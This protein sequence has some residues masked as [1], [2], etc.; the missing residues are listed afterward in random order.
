MLALVGFETSGNIHAADL[1]ASGVPSARYEGRLVPVASPLE[2]HPR[3]EAGRLKTFGFDA[4]QQANKRSQAV[5]A[6]G[7]ASSYPELSSPLVVRVLQTTMLPELHL[8]DVDD[9]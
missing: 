1:A 4:T 8:R 5:A 6:H 9:T 7:R 2:W 3:T